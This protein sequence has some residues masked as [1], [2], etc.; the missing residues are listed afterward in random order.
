MLQS[1]A[2]F[3]FISL[4]DIGFL[5][6]QHRKSTGKREDSYMENQWEGQLLC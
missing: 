1:N 3:L 5:E 6:F 2:G 4:P